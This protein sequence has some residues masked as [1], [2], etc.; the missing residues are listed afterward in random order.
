MVAAA[1]A[2]GAAVPTGAGAV[3]AAGDPVGGAS[4]VAVVA[5]A[6]AVAAAEARIGAAAEGAR[7]ARTGADSEADFPQPA[8]KAKSSVKL[9]QAADSRMRMVMGL[10]LEAVSQLRYTNDTKDRISRK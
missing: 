6:G 7:V 10:S 8:P 1:P 9:A 3:A 5:G 2:S 4:A